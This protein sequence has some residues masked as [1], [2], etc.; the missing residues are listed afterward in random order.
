MNIYFLVEGK[1]EKK[2]YPQWLSHLAPGFKRV[3]SFDEA[4]TDNYFLFC[5]FGYPSILNFIQTAIEDINKC[6]KYSHFVICLDADESTFEERKT[7]IQRFIKDNAATT[8]VD[9]H[10][11]VQNRCF[12]T[13]LPGNRK[14]FT[15]NPRDETLK[16]YCKFYDVSSR[17][18]EAMPNF[19]GF[20]SIS[21]FHKDYLKKMLRAKHIDYTEAR[22][23]EVG[24]P[25][26]IDALKKRVTDTPGDLKSFQGF[27]KLTNEMKESGGVKY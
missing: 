15:R 1:S 4:D 22:P 25:Q 17:D 20:E 27:L 8:N 24:K 12:E 5:S 23:R 19:P 9:T 21:Q 11:V 3:D 26:Y 18:P 10:I 14:A 7:E 13:W 2:V 6:R 16:K